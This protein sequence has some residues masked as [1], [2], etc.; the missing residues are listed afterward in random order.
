M[1]SDHRV[2]RV[3]REIHH[4]IAQYLIRNF[5]TSNYGIVSVTRVESNRELKHAKVFISCLQSPKSIEEIV[6]ELNDQHAEAQAFLAQTLKLRNTPILKFVT[7]TGFEKMLRVEGL[8]KDIQ[9][10][11]MD[12]NE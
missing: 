7:D 6:N 11:K 9:K 4:A 8:L 12:D 10:S 5:N 3:E 2:K 1:K